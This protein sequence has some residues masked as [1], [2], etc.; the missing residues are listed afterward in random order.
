LALGLFQSHQNFS[1]AFFSFVLLIST[2]IILG[3]LQIN[4]HLADFGRCGLAEGHE[5]G[6]KT[7][8]FYASFIYTGL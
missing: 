5:D 3:I 8:M 7:L 6:R 1:L 4:W 2:I